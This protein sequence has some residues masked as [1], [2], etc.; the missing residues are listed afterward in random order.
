MAVR[1]H[2]LKRLLAFLAV[3]AAAVLTIRRDPLYLAGMAI[4]QAPLLTADDYRLMPE[5]GP[6]YQLIEGELIM[7]PAPNRYHQD[8]SRNIEFLMLKY[9]E[10]NP[11]GR[12]YDA[13][14]DVHLGEH[15]VFQPDIVFVANDRLSILTDEGAAGAP[16]LVVEIL[17]ESTAQIDRIPKRKSYA[18]TGVQELCLVDPNAGTIAV[19]RLQLDPENPAATHP[20]EATFTCACFPGLSI[21]AREVFKR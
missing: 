4:A 13:P 19:Y 21:S 10:R 3:L 8:I 9:L 12:L 14:F 20:A 7:S 11:I 18:A 6:R 2:W 15:S 5:T 17:S 16:T 1:Q